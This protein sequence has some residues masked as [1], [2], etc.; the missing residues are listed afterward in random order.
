MM[1]D[2]ADVSVR[3]LLPEFVHGVL[4]AGERERVGAHVAACADCA[5]EV[6]LIR[7]AARAYRGRAAVVDVA[8]IVA[9][10]H[11]AVPAPGPQA[12][13]PARRTLAGG[14][15]DTRRWRIAA[16][17]SFLMLGAVSIAALRGVFSGAN[18]ASPLASATPATVTAPGADQHPVPTPVR[19]AQRESLAKA[20]P[21]AAQLSF[22]GGLSDLT[23]D[24][25][26]ALLREIDSVDA[27][28]S[29][30]PET[31]VPLTIPLR[32]GGYNAK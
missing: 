2:C 4:P 26:K 32:D 9:A 6:A 5:A 12:V 30:D 3:D 18:A 21:R 25:L 7:T 29:T 1:R 31:H 13:A 24:Q 14:S 8:R 16:L 10:L 22:G 17:V 15:G 11:A 23:D 27:L 19:I 28:P 20:A